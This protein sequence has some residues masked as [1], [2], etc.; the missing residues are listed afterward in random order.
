METRSRRAHRS[1][2]AGISKTEGNRLIKLFSGDWTTPV[3]ITGDNELD[4]LFCRNLMLERQ[5]EQKGVRKRERKKEKYFKLS[6]FH[7]KLFNL[8]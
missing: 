7:Y 3:R 8:N 4:F 2:F 6:A 5:R 1:A